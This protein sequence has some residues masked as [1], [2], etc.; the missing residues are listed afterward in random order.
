MWIFC[1]TRI[2]PR[3]WTQIWDDLG[4]QGP[5]GGAQGQGP[6]FRWGLGPGPILRAPGPL[7]AYFW[8][9]GPNFY[10]F[11]APRPPRAHYCSLLGPLLGPIGQG[12]VRLIF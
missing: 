12:C 6:L 4:H 10:I 1:Q 9:P 2:W 5:F 3:F 11:W 8:A 7:G